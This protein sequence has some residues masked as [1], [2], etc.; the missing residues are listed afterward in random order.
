[1]SLVAEA[2]LP[3]DGVISNVWAAIGKLPALICLFYIEEMKLREMA[4]AMDVSEG[5]AKSRLSSA[6][7]EFKKHLKGI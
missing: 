5:M 4:I 2:E 1:M 7:A 6:R 3:F